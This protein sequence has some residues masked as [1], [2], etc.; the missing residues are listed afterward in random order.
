MARRVCP[1]VV[2]GCRSRRTTSRF[3]EACLP[4]AAGRVD[5]NPALTVSARRLEGVQR[6]RQPAP[7]WPSRGAG[8]G[9]SR[10]PERA[11]RGKG[12]RQTEG[13]SGRSS[14]RSFTRTGRGR[15]RRPSRNSERASAT[16]SARGA[17]EMSEARS[18]RIAT[19]RKRPPAMTVPGELVRPAEANCTVVETGKYFL[20]CAGRESAVTHREP[21]RRGYSYVD[22]RL[23][24][25]GPTHRASWPPGSRKATR[26]PGRWPRRIPSQVLTHAAATPR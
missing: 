6:R 22:V 10:A 23:A 5:R 20:S 17:T 16:G 21:T 19:G 11:L 24:E 25:V 12:L 3:K 9:P 26:R 1:R 14:A 15:P 4:L 2:I 8:E 7:R 13:I 18:A